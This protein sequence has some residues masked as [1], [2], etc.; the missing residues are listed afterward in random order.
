MT[1]T[2]FESRRG[3]GRRRLLTAALAAGAAVP[4]GLAG[5]ARSATGDPAPARLTLPRPTGPHPVGTVAL[6]LRG[7]VG[8]G[9]RRR[10][11]MTSLWYPARDVER[12]PRAPW[13]TEGALRELLAASGFAP[14]VVRSRSP[15]VTREP[16]RGGATGGCPSWCSRTGRTATA[17]T[18]R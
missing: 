15:P 4:L 5:P 9:G 2:P 3:F 7:A 6:R 12:Y 18:T 16:R 11:L 8:P 10:D 14:D 17:R 1:F 13:M